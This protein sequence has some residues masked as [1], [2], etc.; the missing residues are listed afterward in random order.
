MFLSFIVSLCIVI[1]GMTKFCIFRIMMSAITAAPTDTIESIRGS[2]FCKISAPV[3]EYDKGT[4]M[5][6]TSGETII[7]N[8]NMRYCTTIISYILKKPLYGLLSIAKA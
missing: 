4:S 6:G 1:L 8:H 5:G 2:T 7:T 3:I